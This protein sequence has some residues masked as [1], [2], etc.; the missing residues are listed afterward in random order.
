M[1]KGQIYLMVGVI[2]I[3]TMIM[4]RLSISYSGAIEGGKL[5]ES[6]LGMQQFENVKDEILNSAG[7]GAA[8]GSQMAGNIRN[9]ISFSRT[10][11]NANSA[12]LD[13]A[14]LSSF[15]YNASAGQ[16]GNLNTT[17]VNFMGR[18]MNNLSMSFA[19]ST[20]GMAT[21][22]DGSSASTN[23]TFTTDADKNY[24]LTLSFDV[25][26]RSFIENITIPILIGQNRLVAFLD[27]NI[28]SNYQ[29]RSDRVSRTYVL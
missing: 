13:C 27:M 10:H 16:T 28:E 3:L 6:G 29:A 12:S 15:Y 9:F 2:I 1:A 14:L 20:F 18:G 24:T 21:L 22:A 8:D 4:I 17:F 23:F 11:L 25:G 7:M 19:G 5:M 26:G